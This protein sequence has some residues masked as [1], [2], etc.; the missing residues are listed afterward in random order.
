MPDF[1]Q[2]GLIGKMIGSI[3]L[4]P[5]V[6]IGLS[7]EMLYVQGFLIAMF[8][9]GT[10]PDISYL[11]DWNKNGTKITH[12]YYHMTHVY[13]TRWYA[14]I[15]CPLIWSYNFHVWI[16]SKLHGRFRWWVWNEGLWVYVLLWVLI[17]GFYKLSGVAI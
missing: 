8:V 5:F 4:I 3:L 9:S 17:Y 14:H 13:I 1:I 12:E 10:L 7:F 6:Y 2:H 15:W 16:D 11:W